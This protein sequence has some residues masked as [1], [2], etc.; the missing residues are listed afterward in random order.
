MKPHAREKSER[1][2][3]ILRAA[4]VCF[5]TRGVAGTRIDE[6]RAKSG[7]ST[8][9][10]YHHFGGKEDLARALY[11]EGIQEH[12]DGFVECLDRHSVAESGVK[13]AIAF[14]F[15][16]VRA[17]PDWA[18]YLFGMREAEFMVSAHEA[19][20]EL[21]K[22]FS[23]RVVRWLEP[24]QEAGRITHMPTEVFFAILLGPVHMF[25]RWWL[26]GRVR[27]EP[28]KAVAAMGEAAWKSLRGSAKDAR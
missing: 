4:L 27:Q 2:Q 28:G 21:N 23:G 24:H 19:M 15:E 18:R 9:S 6:I 13:A 8:G 11:L 22:N 20:R 7:A 14:H 26:A 12:Q 3:T 25:A 16:W 10:I 17:H 1:R 5:S